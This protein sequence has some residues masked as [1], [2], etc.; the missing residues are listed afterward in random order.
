MKE[1][2]FGLAL[3]S[4]TS[5][6]VAQETTDKKPGDDK[7]STGRT[8]MDHEKRSDAASGANGS[9]INTA[10]GAPA[11]SPQG[12]TPPGMQSAPEGHRRQSC[13]RQI[14][15]NKQHQKINSIL[16]SA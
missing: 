3:A 11:E 16:P 7:D 8:L 15:R 9:P 14:P 10:G 12:Q 4:L 1:L 5:I 13:R 6:A 2:I